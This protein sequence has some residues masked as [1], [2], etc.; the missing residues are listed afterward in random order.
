MSLISNQESGFWI[1]SHKRVAGNSVKLMSMRI[2]WEKSE[3]GCEFFDIL[4]LEQGR[5]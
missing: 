5:T 1:Y 3:L 4:V 2:N